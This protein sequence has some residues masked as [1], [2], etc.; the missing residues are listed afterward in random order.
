MN[1]RSGRAA[2]HGCVL[3]GV[4][5]MH[6]FAQETQQEISQLDHVGPWKIVNFLIF[7][8]LIGWFVTR[9]APRFFQARSSDIQKAIREATGLKMDA[10][11][12]YSDIDEKMASLGDE[13]ERIRRQAEI[14]IE[15]EHQRLNQQTE[16]E[17]RR[18]EQNA[19]NEIDA[20]RLEAARR[21]QKQTAQAALALAER[22]LTERF[23]Q[24]EPDTLINDFVHLI[25]R[26]KN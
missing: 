3:L 17:V 21:V 8:G 19:G 23:A 20:L 1:M 22:R 7:V 14:E 10:D 9:S 15:R 2:L 12:R 6:G 18:I 16:A 26:G 25:E 11:L 5:A 24:G 13:V 4:A